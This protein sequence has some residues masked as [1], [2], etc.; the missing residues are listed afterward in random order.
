VASD[1]FRGGGSAGTGS[2][3]DE[4][5]SKD[6]RGSDLAGCSTAAGSSAVDLDVDS[7]RDRGGERGGLE[8]EF[9]IRWRGN[10]STGIAGNCGGVSD[11]VLSVIQGGREVSI[12][13]MVLLLPCRLALPFSLGVGVVS[14]LLS[15]LDCSAE[16]LPNDIRLIPPINT[17]LPSVPSSRSRSFPLC[18]SLETDRTIR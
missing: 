18:L 2:V 1:D 16:L 14:M 7:G 5:V 3:V 8:R 4:R 9:G 15:G 13:E 11:A 12:L 10:A 17:L 6:R